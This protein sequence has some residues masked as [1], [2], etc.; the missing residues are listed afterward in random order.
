M[1]QRIF[2][3]RAAAFSIALHFL[4]F[5]LAGY[6][7]AYV[8]EIPPLQKEEIVEFDIM[9]ND[10]EDPEPEAPAPEAAPPAPVE[11]DPEETE[12]PIITAEEIVPLEKAKLPPPVVKVLEQPG[13]AVPAGKKH[14]AMG[15]PPVVLSRA[16]PSPAERAGFT[17]TIVLKVQILENGLPGN[18][19]V[20]VSSGHKSYN[21]AAIA[22]ARKWRFKPAEDHEGNP[23]ICSTIMSIPF[24]GKEL[25]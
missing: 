4:I 15:K 16:Y 23:M 19:Q 11:P 13:A 18:I 7:A 14:V 22:A 21:D 3:R 2:G 24:S 8:P 10:G 9:G 5:L 20:M 1:P 25:P 17:G 6:A 12:T